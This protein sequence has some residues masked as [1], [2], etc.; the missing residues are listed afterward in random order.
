LTFEKA[1]RWA[2][3]RASRRAG[4]SAGSRAPRSGG[5]PRG[6]WWT[7]R[8]FTA[9][10]WPGRRLG[11]STFWTKVRKTVRSRAPSTL[12]A[13]SSPACAKAPSASIYAVAYLAL[14][15]PAIL[16]GVA[17]T[18][19]SLHATT[20]GYGLVV[21]ALAATT[22]IA[23]WRRSTDPA[24]DRDQPD[25]LDPGHPRRPA[26]S[27]GAGRWPHPADGLG[28]WADRLSQL[29]RVSRDEVGHRGFRRGR[30]A[31]SRALPIAC[32]NA[33]GSACSSRS[34]SREE[35]EPVTRREDP[36]L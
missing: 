32:T 6:S 11:A 17:L 29:Q 35:C 2:Q 5:G 23:L 4:G 8:L 22:A 7:L 26:A 33:P 1:A 30:G 13:A 28:R 9:T 20:Y 25:R 10:T 24:A 3:S 15:T 31:G 36:T 19:F 16:A 18:S 34:N 14:G 27:A 21:M 12:S